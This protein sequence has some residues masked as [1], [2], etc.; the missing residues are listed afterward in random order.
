VSDTL[1]LF[2]RLMLDLYPYLYM[3]AI[4][5][6]SIYAFSGITDSVFDLYY[7]YRAVRRFFLSRNWPKLTLERLEAREQ[8][9]IAII[10]AAWHEEDVIAQTL[11]NACETIRYRNYDIF[12]GTYPNDPATQSEVDRIAQKYPR[13]HKVVTADDGP[14]NKAANLNQVFQAIKD[15]EQRTNQRYE[16]LLMHDSEDVIHPYSLLVCNYLIPRMDMIQTPVFPMDVSLRK[17]THW[18]YADEFAENHTKLLLVR[19]LT[20]GFVPSAGVGTAFTKRAFQLMALASNSDVFTP[21][22]LTEDYELGLRMNLRGIRAAFVLVNIPSPKSLETGK[23]NMADWVA[24]RA[25]FPLKFRQAVR[26]KTRWTIGI[27]LQGWQNLG[28]QGSLSVRWNLF[29]DRKALLTTPA[30]FLGYFVFFYFIL[31]QILVTYYAP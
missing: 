7:I 8:Q 6:G 20:G 11:T 12:V 27:A 21:G 15:F 4:V 28:W 2:V 3:L 10:I 5:V 22:S 26:Q 25:V 13:V 29:Q 1:L 19:E 16:I 9:K 24:T 14:T 18:T 23:R 30:N 31:Y 17:V